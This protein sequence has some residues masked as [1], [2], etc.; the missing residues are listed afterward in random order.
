[1]HGILIKSQVKESYSLLPNLLPFLV[2]RILVRTI[3]V[4]RQARPLDKVSVAFL[5]AKGSQHG[6]L[7]LDPL[8]VLPHENI[9][10]VQLSQ[11]PAYL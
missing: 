6:R 4:Q 8:L 10:L 11:V 3:S 2:K 5:I 9:A 7:G 1:M